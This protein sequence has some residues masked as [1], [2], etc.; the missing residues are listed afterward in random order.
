MLIDSHCHLD[1]S[2]FDHDRVEV[3]NHCRKLAIETIVIPG[4]QASQWHKQIDLCHLYPQL[5]FALGLHPYFLNSFES[6]HLVELSQLLNQY[7]DKVL[8]VGEIGLDS[9]IDVDWKLQLQIFEQQL[10]IAEEHRLPVILHHRNSHNELIR[11]LK[12]KKFTQGGIVHAF[13]GSVQQAKTYIDLGFKIGVGG[14]IT[15]SRASKTRRTI[16]QLPIDCLV[17]ETDAPDMPLMGKQGQRNSPEYLPE[18]FES[19]WSLRNETKQQLLQACSHNVR[20]SLANL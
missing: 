18:I 2:C 4:T 9:H 11:T 7:Q 1:F 13:S 15:Y 19:L 6:L 5:K 20:V 16:A 14:G 12:A 17:L 10:L 3:L 8:A